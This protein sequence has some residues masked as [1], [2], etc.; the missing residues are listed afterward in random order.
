MCYP[1][2]IITPHQSFATNEALSNIAHTTCYNI[3]KWAN[4]NTSEKEL[5]CE[6]KENSDFVPSLFK[7]KILSKKNAEKVN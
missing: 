4:N 5:T 2:I 1:Y 6:E 3:N 7:L